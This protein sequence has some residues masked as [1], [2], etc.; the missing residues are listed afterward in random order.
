MSDFQQYVAVL[1]VIRKNKPEVLDFLFKRKNKKKEQ[2][3]SL[4]AEPKSP[5]KKIAGIIGIALL[6]LLGLAYIGVMCG[7]SA[8][9]AINSG[10]FEEYLYAMVFASQIAV[11]F[12]GVPTSLNIMY[13]SKD[14]AL[15]STL[16]IKKTTLFLARLTLTYLTQVLLSLC[17]VLLIVGTS[18]IAVIIAGEAIPWTFFLV[19]VIVGILTPALP[20]LIVSILAL[21]IMYLI[22]LIKSSKV[23]TKLS[24]GFSVIFGLGLYL[25]MIAMFSMSGAES[26][27]SLI[28][29]QSTVVMYTQIAKLTIFNYPI[30]EA[31]LGN[32]V[33]LNSLIYIASLLVIGGVAVLLSS[34]MY[35]KAMAFVSEGSTN[36]SGNKSHK[37]PEYKQKSVLL[38]FLIK[39]LREVVATPMLMVQALI[40]IVMTPILIFFYSMMFGAETGDSGSSGTM[41][42]ILLNL[43]IMM[44]FMMTLVGNQFAM[45]GFSKEAKSLVVLKSLPIDIKVLCQTKLLSAMLLTVISTIVSLL[46]VVFI[47]G[48]YN[49]VFIVGYTAVL[50]VCGYGMNC[51]ALNIDLSKP[52]T[53]WTNINELTKNNT[54]MI[55]PALMGILFSFVV[56]GMGMVVS[57]ILAELVGKSLAYLIWFS[58]ILVIA[59][60]LALLSKKNYL[61]NPAEKF[62]KIE[63]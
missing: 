3:L 42:M 54:R 63:G 6:V 2:I 13:Y 9:S 31:L 37:S 29:G 55:K 24:T 47:V 28:V 27:D 11:L 60:P 4:G 41:N 17:L 22:A 10:V 8:I 18:G 21:P 51:F 44:S 39:D 30:V 50:L 20:L 36:I 26:D 32:R 56:F 1:K 43:A 34:L 46:S 23:A 25:G 45:V 7:I 19:I 14:N 57:L 35:G 52:N 5:I 12:F 33:A 15:L 40:A 59:V 16:P 61:K 62:A 38:T 49:F 53:S 48:E 58:G